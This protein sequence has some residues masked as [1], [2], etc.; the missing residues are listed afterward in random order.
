MKN[1]PQT[2]L[3]LAALALTSALLSAGCT[4]AEPPKPAAPNAPKMAPGQATGMQYMQQNGG[5]AAAGQGGR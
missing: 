2:L 3:F 4:K 5:N 1:R